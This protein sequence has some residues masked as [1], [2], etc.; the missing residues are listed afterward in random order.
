MHPN[1]SYMGS[2]RPVVAVKLELACPEPE[3]KRHGV[4]TVKVRAE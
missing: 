4:A 3:R 1:Y 2:T